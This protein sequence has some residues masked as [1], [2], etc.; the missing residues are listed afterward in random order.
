[1]GVY[2]CIHTYT[3]ARG[4]DCCYS[5]QADIAKSSASS[6]SWKGA[7]ASGACA[8]NEGRKERK[9]ERVTS[10]RTAQR[11]KTERDRLARHVY[12]YST[13]VRERERELNRYMQ[14]SSCYSGSLHCWNERVYIRIHSC[15]KE[16]TAA[17]EAGNVRQERKR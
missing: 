15:G 16:V 14:N 8:K 4:D 17:A 13:C 12:V 9:T 11:E 1:M 6:G 7:C 10:T 2:I 3:H 5:K